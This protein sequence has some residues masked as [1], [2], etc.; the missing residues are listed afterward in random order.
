MSKND[1]QVIQYVLYRKPRDFPQG[2]MVR[3]WSI[4][5]GKIEPL[6]VVVKSSDLGRIYAHMGSMGLYY[7]PRQTNDDPSIVGVWM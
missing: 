6:A 4:M 5:K 2:Y 3:S 1:E 7:M